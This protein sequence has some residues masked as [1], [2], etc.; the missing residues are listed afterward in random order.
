MS[1]LF[2]VLTFFFV[3][4][5]RALDAEKQASTDACVG[6]PDDD[7]LCTAP[8]KG[9]FQLRTAN[10]DEIQKGQTDFQ[11]TDAAK[12]IHGDGK[13]ERSQANRGRVVPPR[14]MMAKWNK[15][16]DQF[17][18]LMSLMRKSQKDTLKKAKELEATDA[19]EYTELE[20]DLKTIFDDVMTNEE[21]GQKGVFDEAL[22][23]KIT[24]KWKKY[25]SNNFAETLDALKG[26]S[27]DAFASA[28]DV[29][30]EQ[31][32][33]WLDF[34]SDLKL[35]GNHKFLHGCRNPK[36]RAPPSTL[37]PTGQPKAPAPLPT[38]APTGPPKKPAPPPTIAPT[39]PPEAPEPAATPS[40]T[41]YPDFWTNC[42]STLGC[43]LKSTRRFKNH[44]DEC[45]WHECAEKGLEW[46]QNMWQKCPGQAPLTYYN[47]VT[48]R[49]W[50][51]PRTHADFWTQCYENN[52]CKKKLPGADNEKNV[53]T[54]RRRDNYRDNCIQDECMKKGLEWKSW[55]WK[56]CGGW[57]FK[58]ECGL[59]RPPD[60]PM[61]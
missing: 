14:C 22:Y 17:K 55:V 35:L 46:N 61:R 6:S 11:G 10:H 41:P 42:Y 4:S 16:E 40:P 25:K 59:A 23:E 7:P 43:K 31:K 9:L 45:I 47:D 28:V 1:G 19:K 58:G 37:A 38:S 8:E 3:V 48:Y 29:V 36:T 15:H 33:L 52:E 27:S 13:R 30:K 54:T 12:S 5:C 18:I 56:D 60:A 32:E 49:G 2:S 21:L 20:S 50:C 24:S 53:K 26:Q 51:A 39:V 34:V 57:K 44:R